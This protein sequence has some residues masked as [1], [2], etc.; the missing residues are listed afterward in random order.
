M[1]SS[2]YKVGMVSTD[3]PPFFGGMGSHVGSLLSGLRALGV[4]TALF[5]KNNRSFASKWGAIGFSIGLH[6]ALKTW[7][8][9]EKI[10]ILHLHTGPGGAFLRKKV[11]SVPLV[12]TANHTY[13]NQAELPFQRWKKFFI[14]W[15][16]ATYH[17]AD[18]ICAL[19]KDTADSVERDYGIDRAKIRV[20]PCG[21]LLAPW[22]AADREL[23]NRDQHSCVFIGRPQLRKGWDILRDAWPLVR[24]RVPDAVLHVIG[25]SQETRDDICFH[26]RLPDADVRRLVGKSSLILC[27]SRL[28]GFGLAAAEAIAAGTPVV[29]TRVRGLRQVLRDNETGILVDVSVDALATA[30]SDILLDTARWQALHDGC[31]RHRDAFDI[32]REIAAHQSVYDEVYSSSI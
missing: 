14:P 9:R 15:E 28:E 22:M 5:T 7:V 24:K 2:K 19:S 29:A 21:F 17:A 11:S 23:E 20:I 12:V 8:R 10:D 18:I 13:A 30:I 4:D 1:T 32:Q 26:G 27:P 16:R 6:A 25:F 31:V 3:A